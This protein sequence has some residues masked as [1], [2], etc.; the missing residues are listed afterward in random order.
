MA[1]T[2]DIK[3]IT[4]IGD[5]RFTITEITSDGSTVA[6]TNTDAGMHRF[7]SAWLQDIDDGA[8]LGLE[9][10]DATT[11]TLTAAIGNTQKQTLFAL[12]Y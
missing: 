4:Y 2:Y 5:M 1:N 9:V 12:G 6:I 10:T 3:K 7:I 11:L 8:A